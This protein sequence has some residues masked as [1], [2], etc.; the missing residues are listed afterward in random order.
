MGSFF[1]PT[2][3]FQQLIGF[4]RLKNISCSIPPRP[5]FVH[6]F[7]LCPTEPLP[8]AILASKYSLPQSPSIAK[9]KLPAARRLR[10]PCPSPPSSRPACRPEALAGG[11]G[12]GPPG[13]LDP[14]A[15]SWLAALSGV[16]TRQNPPCLI[17]ATIVAYSTTVIKPFR[18]RA[19]A[20][21][22]TL[23]RVNG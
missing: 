1:D 15:G 3:Y 13:C 5:R 21:R 14:L 12:P 16:E 10:L 11:P 9:P 8:Q 18:L 6:F 7:F 22:A 2:P 23:R 20:S 19:Q 4:V 17:Y